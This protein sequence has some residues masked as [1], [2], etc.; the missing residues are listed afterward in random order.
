VARDYAKEYREF[1]GKPAEIAKRASRNAARKKM[2]EKL[3]ADAVK[4]LDVNHRDQNPKNNSA[5]NLNLE[6]PSVNR[7]RKKRTGR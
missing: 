1:H 7:A 5:K 3:G 6:K 4:G 2:V